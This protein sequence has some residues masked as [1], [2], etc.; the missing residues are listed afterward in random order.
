MFER[1]AGHRVPF[2]LDGTDCTLMLKLADGSFVPV[3]VRAAE[4]TSMTR[5]RSRLLKRGAPR[6]RILVTLRSL[7]ERYAYDRQ[8]RRVPLGASGR[9]QAPFGYPLGHY[10]HGGR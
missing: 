10:V 3:L 5:L 9:Q 8:M 7:Q 6:G 2:P 4:L 1:A